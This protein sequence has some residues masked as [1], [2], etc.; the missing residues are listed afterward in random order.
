[1]SPHPLDR[2]RSRVER[3]VS[4]LKFSDIVYLWVWVGYKEGLVYGILEDCENI[5]KIYIFPTDHLS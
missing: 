3:Q 5:Y 1:M 4:T 2:S